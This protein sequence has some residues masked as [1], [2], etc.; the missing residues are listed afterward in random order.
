MGTDLLDAVEVLVCLCLEP[1]ADGCGSAEEEEGPD[2]EEL[3]DVL[4][5]SSM[6]LSSSFSASGVE[7]SE[8]LFWQNLRADGKLPASRCRCAISRHLIA[9][10]LLL[11]IVYT[12][13]RQ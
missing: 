2:E 9:S 6:M 7:K 11:S 3:D 5:S 1:D 8:M 4:F 13:P 10:S 12:C